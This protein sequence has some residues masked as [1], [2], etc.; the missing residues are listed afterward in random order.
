[1]CFGYGSRSKFNL[2]KA[3]KKINNIY[4][5]DFDVNLKSKIKEYD[6]L[7]HLSKREGL[8]VSVMQSL[9]E[10]LPIICYNIRGNNDLIK[11]TFNGFFVKSHKDVLNKIYYLNLEDKIF[12]KMRLN[13][14]KSI[15]K[16]FFKKKINF[17]IYN[18]FRNYS[19]L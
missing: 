3:K 8:P 11:N 19:K 13:A 9:A 1:M 6:I 10:G 5:R 15:N 16:N 18:I 17:D 12:N 4:F 14:K 7:L 2:I